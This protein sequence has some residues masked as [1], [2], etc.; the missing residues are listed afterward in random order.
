MGTNRSSNHAGAF[1][2]AWRG[3]LDKITLMQSFA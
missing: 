2:G 1:L 3:G